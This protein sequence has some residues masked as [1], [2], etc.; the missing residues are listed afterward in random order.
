MPIS[1]WKSCK[2]SISVLNFWNA[3]GAEPWQALKAAFTRNADLPVITLSVPFSGYLMP[4]VRLSDHAAFWD[5]GYPAVMVTDTAFF[6]NPHYHRR[7]DTPD[8]LDYDFLRRVTQLLLLSSLVA[9][10]G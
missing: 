4:S 5:Q 8:T 9:V 6:R 10:T 1:C 3:P 2:A 7:S